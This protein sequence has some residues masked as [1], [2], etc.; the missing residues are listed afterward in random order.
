MEIKDL[1]GLSKPLTRLIEVI[2][3]GIG[4]VSRPYLLKKTAEAKA[5]EVRVI[6]AA[7]KEVAEQHQLPVVYKEGAIEVWQKPEDKTLLLQETKPEDR[8]SLRLD[9]QERKRQQNIENITSVAAS[10]LVEVVEVPDEKPDEDWIARFFKAAEDVSSD[11]MQDLWGRILAGE[12][13]KPGTYSLKTL[14][15]IKNITK[16][17]ASLLE[18]I[19]KLAI[20]FQGT[21]FVALHDNW[22]QNNRNI[23]P[24]H[25][26]E[27]SEL[28]AMYPTDLQLR[29]FMEESVQEH[30]IVAGDLM[31]LI[32]RGEI[33]GEVQLPIWKFTGLGRELL[34]LIP[35]GNDEEYV[36]SLGKF[37][38]ERKGTAFIAKVI[39][40]LPNGQIRY[41]HLRD[42]TSTPA[43]GE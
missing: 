39:E 16:N 33:S 8:T 5:H 20:H 14:E 3:D 18:H 32:K 2:S 21:T 34:G 43:T 10:E 24:G 42:I 13:K 35:K 15:F 12:I 26:F 22:L 36:E 19:G 23:F 27:I 11:Q 4:A 25:H 7:L 31:L 40:H 9:Y 41:Q 29:L 37:F 6:S 38:V 17:D 28:G 1:A 30:V